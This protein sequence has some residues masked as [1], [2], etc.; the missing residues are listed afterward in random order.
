MPRR[1]LRA[2]NNVSKRSDSREAF[3]SHAELNKADFLTKRQMPGVCPPVHGFT[4]SLEHKDIHC[5]M[6]NFLGYEYTALHREL[7]GRIFLVVDVRLNAKASLP[8][9]YITHNDVPVDIFERMMSLKS[10]YHHLPTSPKYGLPAELNRKVSVLAKPADFNR[11]H[12]LLQGKV[13]DIISAPEQPY[14]HEFGGENLYVYS[15]SQEAPSDDII[16]PQV[17]YACLLAGELSDNIA[18]LSA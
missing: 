8:H 7:D 9:C 16:D 10:Q 12:K 6:G 13:A 14:L 11:W 15:Y 3:L 17:G 2:I 18:K 1:L 4:S 5:A